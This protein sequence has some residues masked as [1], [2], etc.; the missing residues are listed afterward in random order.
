MKSV[1]GY[2]ELELRQGAEYHEK[3]IRL[4]SGRNALEYILIAKKYQK[5]YLPYFTCNVLLEPIK[6]LN[7]KFEFYNINHELEPVFDFNKIGDSDSFI[8]TNYFGIK[9]KYI[10][11]LV[12]F[13]PNL[14]IDN[15]QAFFERPIKETD[16][17]YSPRKFFGV[18][19]GAYLYTNKELTIEFPI[20]KSLK[21]F[22]HLIKRTEDGAEAGYADYKENDNSLSGE[23]IKRMSAI[24]QALLCNIDYKSIIERRRKN[25]KFLHDSL[26]SSNELKLPAITNFT[27]LVFPYLSMH[28]VRLKEHLIKNRIFIPTFWPNVFNDVNK[29]SFEYYLAERTVCLPIDQRYDIKDMNNNL[30]LL[31][32]K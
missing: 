27:P 7:L 29:E 30:K 3:A 23:P 20:D 24:T 10:S 22:S 18:P 21:R 1:G 13:C 25:Y 12:N 8:Y 32:W 15:S 19:D 14:I 4:N 16:T 2:F 17:F 28:G 31:I 5:V 26:S 11:E 9:N 6:R